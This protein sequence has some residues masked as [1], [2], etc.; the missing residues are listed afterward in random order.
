[1]EISQING[2]KS[3][4]KSDK[5]KKSNNKLINPFERTIPK[6]NEKF[7]TMTNEER[8]NEISNRFSKDTANSNSLNLTNNLKNN[9]SFSSLNELTNENYT[10]L[11]KKDNIESIP[12]FASENRKYTAKTIDKGKLLL[13]ARYIASQ[14]Q[15]RL[16]SINQH[17][18]PIR[19]IATKKESFNTGDKYKQ[20][21]EDKK[22]IKYANLFLKNLEKSIFLFNIK[23][24]EDC[25]NKLV[26]S[27]II[28]DESEFAE[29]L[30]VV[31]GCDKVIIGEFLS[32]DKGM[33]KNVLILQLFMKKIQFAGCSFLDS[34]RF[35]FTRISLPKD[36]GLI[37]TIIDEFT[38]AYY[39]DNNPSPN[40]ADSN[41][42]YLLA[43][44]ILALNTMFTRTDIKNLIVLKK[45]E[46]IKMNTA[47]DANFLSQIYD[48]LKKNKIEL[49]SDYSEVV[50]K[51][52]VVL[53]KEQSNANSN[54]QQFSDKEAE[55]YLPMLQQGQIFLKYGNYNTPHER[56]FQLSQDK[57]KLLWNKVSGC[58][59]F[60][61]S[62]SITVDKMKDVYIGVD[63]SNVFRKFDIP[64]DYDQ[65]C[66]SIVTD[67]RSLDL[68]NENEAV[69][70]KWFYA[71]KFLIKQAKT[72]ESMENFK[73]NY[74]V[75]EEDLKDIWINEIIAKWDHYRDYLFNKKEFI[76]T[77]STTENVT[78][79]KKKRIFHFFSHKDQNMTNNE[80][81][82]D[83]NK[84]YDLWTLGL[85]KDIRMKMW[86][87]IIGNGSF[88]TEELVRLY[89]DKIESL[90]S[91][92]FEELQSKV[93]Q[94]ST[95]LLLFENIELN[96]IT[97]DI[98]KTTNY[99]KLLSRLEKDKIDQIEFM[100]NLFKI[101]RI[102]TLFRKDITY[103]K[104]LVYFS[105]IFLLNSDNYV[106]AFKNLVNFVVPTCFGKYLK[107]DEAFIKIRIDKFQEILTSSLP[108]LSEHFKKLEISVSF[109][110]ISW[111]KNGFFKTFE[112]D[113]LLRL[114]DIYLLKGEV[115]LFEIGIAIL[116]MEENDLYSLPIA[117][118]L[119]SLKKIPEN[120]YTEEEFFNILY[121]IE[122]YNEFKSV[123]Y[124]TKLG[125]EK[126]MLLQH[127]MSDD[128]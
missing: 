65:N 97:N 64:V 103:S 10:Y 84:F 20:I 93:L 12:I 28:F 90:E 91:I 83:E 125:N 98:I 119:A 116:K 33:N 105:V 27:H 45:E 41:A 56:F 73:K 112:Y 77:N 34:M 70:V 78:L 100:N 24:Y 88:I 63:S 68:R 4:N 74:K 13:K 113:T 117:G 107:H 80:K 79:V 46:F 69:S 55:E 59:I 72:K 110:L 121:D 102:F 18:L 16:T 81:L 67:K 42:L 62:K 31:S 36:A 17:Q 101:I 25:Y 51:R 118:I 19:S 1:M 57:K 26:S 96:E 60:S 52:Y 54:N 14:A 126:L 61:P 30:L 123:E 8:K 48:D 37:L 99:P 3:S 82:F 94:S 9:I 86:P 2:Q 114:W 111:M 6:N 128:L 89:L 22:I 106:Q 35:L 124:E 11:I 127:Y 49:K 92:N 21:E 44:S 71:I 47:C 39:N 43:S 40:Y 58:K 76:N 87:I 109:Y 38:K 23:K 104:Q 85:P 66:F 15:I 7:N 29:F 115:F 32:K 50:H 95:K 122:L 120:K 5:D 75:N 53:A 108:K